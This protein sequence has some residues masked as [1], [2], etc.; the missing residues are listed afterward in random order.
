MRVLL[1]GAGA[2]GSVLAAR[3]ESA[4]AAVTLLARHEQASA[5]ERHGLL[6]EGVG[7]GVF[8]PSARAALGSEPPEDAYVLAVKSF[9]LEAAAREL[10]V[11][12][13]PRP[14]LLVQNGL[15]VEVL[16]ARGL[17]AGGWSEP[18]RELVRAVQSIPATSIGPGHVRAT[19]SGEIVLPDPS[20]AGPAS[21]AAAT[22]LG[23]LRSAPV[24]VRTTWDLPRE[25]WR[26][27]LV[28]A[29]INP[30]TAIHGLTNGALLDPPLREEA[31]LLLEEARGVAEAEG[32]RIS[33]EEAVAELD[34][35]VRA[36]AT[37]RSS[38]LQDVER[39]RP[40]EIDAISGAVWARGRAAGLSLPA[41]EA[42]IR[43][44]RARVGGAPQR[45]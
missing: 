42:A 25:V 43:A 19:G 27:V 6:I 40:T 38:M 3:L 4:G 32:V 7:A 33:R 18:A 9:D 37:N 2:V 44:V 12:R 28:N 10:A 30:V 31:R 15:D 22:W 20:V 8:R 1:V 21:S 13:T 23:I 36:T 16:A 17:S 35:V 34:R 39:G 45:S 14:T 26:K 29:A 5:V 11:H 41:T 24:P